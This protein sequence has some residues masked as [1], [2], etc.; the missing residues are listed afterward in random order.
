MRNLTTLAHALRWCRAVEP[1]LVTDPFLTPA[2]SEE[3]SLAEPRAMGPAQV[4]GRGTSLGRYVLLEALGVGGQGVVYAA[5]DP[6]LDRKVALKL[7]RVRGEGGASDEQRARLL[8]E[9]QVLAQLSHPNVVAVHDVGR[10]ADQLF[11]AMEFM[12]GGTLSDWLEKKPGFTDVLARFQEAGRGLAAAHAAGIVHRDFKPDNV[13]LDQ[14]G[15]AHVTDFGLARFVDG[16]T[17]IVGGGTAAWMSPEQRARAEV[18]PASDQYSFCVALCW[19]LSGTRFSSADAG[20][21][22]E[23]RLPAV[24]PAWLRRVLARGLAPAPGDRFP[25][26]EALLVALENDPAKARRRLLNA[27]VVVAGL[28]AV[29]LVSGGLFFRETPAQRLARECA[30]SVDSTLAQTWSA[31]RV[32]AMRQVFVAAAGAPGRDAFAKVWAQLEPEVRAWGEASR[33]SCRLDAASAEQRAR[34][35][36]L[37]TRGAVLASLAEVFGSADAQ[38]VE[39]AHAT[40]VLEVQPAASC[41][42]RGEESFALSHDT[43]ADRA[44]RPALSRTRV[45]RAAGRYAEGVSAALEVAADAHEEKAFRVEAE[46]QLLAGLLSAELRRPDAESL[47]KSAVSLAERAGSDEERARA[48]V[49]LIGW[50]S[51]RDRFDAAHEAASAADDITS[52]LGH[53]EFLEALRLTQVGQ[54]ATR[55]GELGQARVAFQQVLALRRKRYPPW[56]PLVT[57]ALTNHALS[58]PAAEAQA[59][60]LEV[61][62]IRQAQLGPTHPETAVAEHNVGVVML[63]NGSCQGARRHVAAALSIRQQMPQADPARLGREFVVLARAQE[64]LGE[65]DD[66][67][68]G[69][70]RGIEAMRQGG[71]P[72]AEL[73][74]ELN[75]LRDLLERLER[76]TEELERVSEALR[77]LE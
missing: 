24:L 6:Q 13:L 59:L 32:D 21:S 19:A 69:M 71:A 29:G 4:L 5:Y 74:R 2:D 36:C 37:S 38:V 11:I 75:H 30:A 57:R 62:Q 46:A 15:A 22:V 72:D 70:E 16:D 33:A 47:L 23:A 67:A 10:F 18:G 48:W 14:H 1:D 51:E 43:D 61:L 56:H 49:G 54:L 8:R 50:Y 52:R 41:Q 26:M 58:L 42:S 35:Q 55:E 25:S 31:S 34:A 39:N 27:A 77:Q 53:P 3:Q 20:G 40:V 12:A 68:A 17:M 7:V 44:L 66:A 28:V 45:L 60:L 76:P 9:A 65:L 63:G 64:C 73:R